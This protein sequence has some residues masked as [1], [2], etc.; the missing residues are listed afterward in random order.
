MISYK[1][2]IFLYLKDLIFVFK[3]EMVIGS[4]FSGKSSGLRISTKFQLRQR[5]MLMYLKEVRISNYE[6]CVEVR[7]VLPMTRKLWGPVFLYFVKI[8]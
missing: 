8:M 6:L 4:M 3:L 5:R 2:A 7:N 1:T